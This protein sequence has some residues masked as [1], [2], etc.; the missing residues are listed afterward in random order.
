MNHI[1]TVA[2]LESLRNNPN[3]FIDGWL[4]P[5][6]LVDISLIDILAVH[7]LHDNVVSILVVIHLVKLYNIFMFQL[8]RWSK[9]LEQDFSLPPN[10][11]GIFLLALVPTLRS[12]QYL[13]MTL[14]AT[15]IS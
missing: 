4:I 13:A 12:R 14:M 6:F 10:E 5:N 9:Y 11:S 3:Y 7:I 1:T 8:S 15:A 2:I